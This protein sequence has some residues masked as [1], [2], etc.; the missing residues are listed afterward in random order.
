MI[1][2][3]AL[4]AGLTGALVPAAAGAMPVPNPLPSSWQGRLITAAE[5]QIGRTVIYDPAYVRL[6]YPGGD[7]P[8]ERGVC[9]DVIVRA[10][11]AGLGLD[12]QK[13]VHEDMKR[14]F[15]A[16]PKAWGLSRPDPN[17]DHRRVLNL[18]TFF[19]RKG[20][21]LPFT[22]AMDFRPGELATL[23]LP[24]NLPHIVVVTGKRAP[25]GR[26]LCVHN[27]GQ[28]TRREDVLAE[29]DLV[30]RFRYAPA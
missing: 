17:I 30:G 29:W 24:G 9:C 28:G 5:S 27:V 10:Y 15:S 16:Y 18:E 23:R 7:V 11:R 6:A 12:L 14:A 13:L 4:I 19:R 8:I 20:A 3:R 22:S 25:S 21:A 2:R 26:Y 1:H